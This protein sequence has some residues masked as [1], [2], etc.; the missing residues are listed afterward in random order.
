MPQHAGI[1]HKAVRCLSLGKQDTENAHAFGR[2]ATC[3]N[4]LSPRLWLRTHGGTGKGFAMKPLQLWYQ[5]IIL[6]RK[7][8]QW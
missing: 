4:E 5:S 8:G 3:R 1:G 2:F 7:N 6:N